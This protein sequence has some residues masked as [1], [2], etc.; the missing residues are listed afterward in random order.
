MSDEGLDK[1]RARIDECDHAIIQKLNE[2]ANAALEI[3][4]IKK[5]KG[6]R[7]YSPEREKKVMAKVSDANSGP[8][9]V[10]AVQSIYRE[11]ISVTRALEQDLKI[12][13]L[14]P[15]GTFTHFAARSAFG[16]SAT[17]VPVRTISG[18]FVEVESGRASYGVVPIENSTEGVVNHTLDMFMDSEL[19]IMSEIMLNVHH[20][21]LSNTSI[22][23]V[24]KLYSH[25]QAIAQCRQWIEEHLPEVEIVH[26]VSTANAAAQASAEPG[27]AAIASELAA[28][29][30]SLNVVA[31]NI[32]SNPDNV[33]RFFT[34]SKEI[35]DPTGND[36]TSVMFSIKD[37]VGALF[38]MLLP[39]TRHGVN[40]TKIES[41][42]TRKKVWEYVFF[43]DLIG[44]C[45]DENVATA[46]EELSEHC[47]FTKVLG[48]YP[49]E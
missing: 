14:G 49:R 21:L 45:N 5:D 17:H 12:A 22:P 18:V 13:Y 35:A 39:F 7:I 9:P 33:T 3:G 20:H 29:L 23:E 46:L 37:R 41:R 24:K 40:L 10:E 31:E 27:S 42:P 25:P 26:A 28:E 4:K 38:E 47:V 6:T 48:S 36:K 32:H 11:I 43:V 15:E 44:H 2:R 16:S 19:K 8:L 1:W 30:Y 34:I